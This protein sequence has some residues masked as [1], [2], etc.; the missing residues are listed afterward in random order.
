MALTCSLGSCSLDPENIRRIFYADYASGNAEVVVSYSRRL[1]RA[2][3]A[4]KIDQRYP[5]FPFVGRDVA[6]GMD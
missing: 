1:L 5:D 3:G 4:H 6:Q 2:A